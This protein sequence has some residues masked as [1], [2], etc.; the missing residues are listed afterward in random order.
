MAA[1]N[2]YIG[3]LSAI[4]GV[5]GIAA[6]SNLAAAQSDLAAPGG[7]AANAQNAQMN[8]RVDLVIDSADLYYTLKLL[9][10]QVKADFALDTSLRGTPVTV[11]L[12]NQPFRVALETVLKSSPTPL[13][14]RVE[15]GIYSVVPKV[16]EQLPPPETVVTPVIEVQKAHA[17]RI[18]SG[19]DFH[20]NPI[21]ILEM[22]R[23]GTIL[24][25]FLGMSGGAGGG[26][27]GGFGGGGGFGGMTGGYGGGGG[28]G[29]TGGGGFGGTG[30][31]GFGGTGGG[32]G[33]GGTG[34]GGAGGGGM[35]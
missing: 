8:H 6:A 11:S 5:A 13:T 20:Y 17:Q 1:R 28:M 32:G 10:A 21:A 12:H 33:F 4:L 27:V 24:Y 22:L 19:S 31:G 35:R 15:N 25:A 3:L 23:A 2:S 9:F 7:A 18:M 26:G 29:A 30:G 34:G 16:A 14:Y